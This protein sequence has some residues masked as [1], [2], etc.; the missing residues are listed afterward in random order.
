MEIGGET[1]VA[2]GAAEANALGLTTQVPIREIFLTSGRSRTLRLGNREIELKHGSRWLLSLGNQ[3]A[4]R[5]IRALS[6]LGPEQ[7][8]AALKVLRTQLPVKEWHALQ[9][10]M[11]A[12][13]SWMARLI[14]EANKHA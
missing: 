2:S 10:A 12:V 1:I 3:P 13:P 14:G 11:A 5:A 4:G 9:P 6:W 7:A 8:P